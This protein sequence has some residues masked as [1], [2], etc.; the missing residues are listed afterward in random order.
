MF[1]K[2]YLQSLKYVP[3]LLAPLDILYWCKNPGGGKCQ[4]CHSYTTVWFGTMHYTTLHHITSHYTTLHYTTLHH[5]TLHYTTLHYKCQVCHIH[6][7]PI[8]S[9]R[10]APE[11]GKI[12][13]STGKPKLTPFNGSNFSGIL[14]YIYMKLRDF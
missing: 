6:T 12:T 10:L 9:V 1:T 8:T 4:V 11:L 7:T 3:T 5:N 14:V 2:S 13:F